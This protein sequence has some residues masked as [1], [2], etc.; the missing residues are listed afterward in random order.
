MAQENFRQNRIEYIFKIL[1]QSE[2]PTEAI[3]S[4]LE[5]IANHFSF[6]RGYIF[7]TSKDGQTTSNTFEWC[8]EGI[9]PERENLQ[10]LPIDVVSAANAS[11]YKTGTYIVKTPDAL[12]VRQRTLLQAQGIKSLFQFGIFDKRM[13]LG[14]IGFDNCTSE[15]L[16]SNT[17]VDELTTTCNILATFFVKQRNDEI[18]AQDLQLRQSVMNHLSN[19]VYVINPITFEVLFMN[20]QTKKWVGGAEC[21]TP[22]YH[23]F[24]GYTEPC[25]DCPAQDLKSAPTQQI[26]REIRNDKFKIWLETTVSTLC[27][28]DGS[29]AYLVESADITRQ[30]EDHLRHIAEL[31][32]LAFVD[33][34]TG[35]PTFCKFEKDAQEILQKQPNTARFLVKLD[36]DNFKI[37]N[38]L[39]GYEKGDK[40]LRCVAL[41]LK[42]AARNPDEIFARISSDEYIA[43][44]SIQDSSTITTLYYTFLQNFE[45][46]MDHDF[47]FK[48]TFPHGIYVI[49][50]GD[51]QNLD[52]KD[53]FEK[54]NIAHKAAK[55]NKLKKFLVYDESMTKEVLR[56]KEIE[57][58]MLDALE[59][60]EFLIYLQPK[61]VLATERIGG[62]EALSRWQNENPDL[63]FPGSFIPIF[64]KNGFI[65]KLDFYVLEKVC[66][67]IKGWMTQG[68]EPIVVSVNFSRIHLSNPNFVQEL[69]A[70]V[71]GIGIE[72]KYIEIEITE[73]AIY[74]N[75]ETLEVLLIDLHNHGFTMSMDDF[76]SGYSSLG[77]LKNLP[78]DIIK[79]DR[80]FFANQ[81]DAARSKIV[82]R[83]IITM[84]ADL[85]IHIVAEG[86]EEQQH[87]D[88]LR[89]LQ[90]DMVQGYYYQKP[91]PDKDFT[92]FIRTPA[93]NRVKAKEPTNKTKED[94]KNSIVPMPTASDQET[95]V[96]LSPTKS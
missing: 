16:P 40:V 67:L 32:D 48:F 69:C 23:F 21:H 39:Y 42:E 93:R 94:E 22:C 61:Y 45:R 2:N 66:K 53:L 7:E 4:V 65:T 11:F 54:V 75:I 6:E 84:S 89:E 63:F 9:T 3:H 30:K 24:R 81:K 15:A 68:I 44:F 90:C 82:L 59:H 92:E 13:L 72:R 57:N 86:V 14:F 33:K 12:Q 34:L 74:D 38:Q 95:L 52:I 73:T 17:E 27:W 83:S 20:D 96:I 29:M 87:I 64:E 10:N 51:M 49:R 41:A 77:L 78:V 91:M 76:G 88:L 35:I 50:P 60:D 70:I 58:K 19:F 8:A 46:L 85:G 62:A 47:M 79:I 55:S 31:E 56:T 5:L 80:S 36:I 37:I 26:C 18:I 43:L 1:Y 28:T 25:A 71:D